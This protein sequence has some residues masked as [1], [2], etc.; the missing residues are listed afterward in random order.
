[1]SAL[2]PSPLW[3]PRLPRSSSCTPT[4]PC[5]RPIRA[6]SLATEIRRAPYPS[7]Y[8]A[9]SPLAIPRPQVGTDTRSRPARGYAPRR[10]ALSRRS[11]S[12]GMEEGAGKSS[13]QEDKRG[14]VGTPGLRA[15]SQHKPFRGTGKNKDK[16]TTFV[17]WPFIPGGSRCD[18]RSPLPALNQ[19]STLV[20]KIIKLSIHKVYIR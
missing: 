11:P 19:L 3:L 8:S 12:G 7:G 6:S 9:G 1:L 4:V 13:R 14:V 17:S 18:A 5:T 15:P 2:P 10:G 16:E 20:Y